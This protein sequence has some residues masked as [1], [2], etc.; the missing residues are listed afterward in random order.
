MQAQLAQLSPEKVKQ[1]RE[2]LQQE[3][4]N[5]LL[6]L[7]NARAADRQVCAVNWLTKAALNND[8]EL[9]AEAG[10]AAMD[11]ERLKA[12]IGS[13]ERIRDEKEKPDDL[14]ILERIDT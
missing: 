4:S 11:A 9:G 7:L 14:T 8:A 3:P 5:L 6:L 13:V 2:W 12:I 10:R 1:L